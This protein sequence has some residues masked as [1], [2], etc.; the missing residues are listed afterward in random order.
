MKSALHKC[1]RKLDIGAEEMRF[2][3]A[4]IGEKECDR[5]S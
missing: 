4:S 2:L 3:S 5:A 1:R